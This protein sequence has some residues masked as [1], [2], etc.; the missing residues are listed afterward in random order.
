MSSATQNMSQTQIL[1]AVKQLPQSELEDFVKKVLVFQAKKRTNNLPDTETRLLKSVY[2]TFSAENLARLKQLRE[3]SEAEY[4]SEKEYEELASLS[5][6]LE[7][8]HARRMKKLAE[9]SKL[10]GL[11]LEE[12]MSQIG[13]K[14]PNYD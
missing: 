12:T 5:D 8:F 13:I 2:R 14:F 7:E 4:L 6:S 10:R 11:S 9:L 3:K 1:D